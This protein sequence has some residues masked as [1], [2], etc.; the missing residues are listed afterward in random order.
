MITSHLFQFFFELYLHPRVLCKGRQNHSR[1]KSYRPS[2]TYSNGNNLEDLAGTSE[3][4]N[5]SYRVPIGNLGT[6]FR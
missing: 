1:K 6:C 2:K 5:E 3:S 4:L